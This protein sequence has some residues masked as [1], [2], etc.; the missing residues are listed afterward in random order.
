MILKVRACPAPPAPDAQRT[1]TN[2]TMAHY[3]ETLDQSPVA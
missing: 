2:R 3:A 1:I